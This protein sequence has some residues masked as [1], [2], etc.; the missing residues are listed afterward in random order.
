MN[1]LIAPPRNI[2]TYLLTYLLTLHSGTVSKQLIIRWCNIPSGSTE[3]I[4]F[5]GHISCGSSH[6]ITQ[7]KH[8]K[9][10]KSKW[11]W[12]CLKFSLQYLLISDFHQLSTP[13]NA[14]RKMTFSNSPSTPLPSSSSSSF[15]FIKKLT[16]RNLYNRRSK[17]RSVTL[18]IIMSIMSMI[19][20]KT[21]I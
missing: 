20:R 5:C 2:L 3:T 16:K 18:M 8:V 7:S 10:D 12:Q 6:G 11:N 17:H 9:W 14:V 13:L 15:S 21:H 1:C 4:T 19:V